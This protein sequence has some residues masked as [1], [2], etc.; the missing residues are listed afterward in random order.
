M[1]ATRL[2]FVVAVQPE[3]AGGADRLKQ[4]IATLPGRYVRHPL[5]SAALLAADPAALEDSRTG[6]RHDRV[7]RHGGRARSEL[8]PLLAR[9]PPVPTQVLPW[10]RET[11]QDR[12]RL[13]SLCARLSGLS[14]ADACLTAIC[15][16]G[17]EG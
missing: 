15:G 17:A 10:T 13:W 3:T 11:P 5:L 7:A 4:P 12:E 1:A 6:G 9:P 2:A 14:A 8:G 16:S